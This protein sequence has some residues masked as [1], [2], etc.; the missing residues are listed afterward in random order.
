MPENN[1]ENKV[2]QQLQGFKLKPSEEVWLKVEKR[3]GEKKKRRLFFLLFLMGGLA[4]LGY[5]QR[6]NLFPKHKLSFPAGKILNTKTENNTDSTYPLPSATQSAQTTSGSSPR[7]VQEQPGITPA[8]QNSQEDPA[9]IS[10]IKNQNNTSGKRGSKTIK[11]RIRSNANPTPTTFTVRKETS[12][13][14]KPDKIDTLS[15]SISVT[16]NLFSRNAGEE[17]VPDSGGVKSDNRAEIN[18]RETDTISVDNLPSDSRLITQPQTSIF[19]KW[20]WGITVSPGIVSFHENLFSLGA[21]KSADYLS[22]GPASGGSIS[23]PAVPSKSQN[24]IAFQ[25]GLSVTQHFSKRNSVSI[26]LQ[27]GYYTEKIKVGNRRD[28][29]LQ[30]ASPLSAIY[31]A[32]FAYGTAS[33]ATNFTNRYHFIELPVAFQFRITKNKNAAHPSYARLG[34]TAG[35]LISARALAY[36]TSFGGIYYENS[37]R[38][39][40]MQFSL[41]AGLAWTYTT[42]AKWEW[43]AGPSFDIH[44]SRLTKNS[45]EREK[46]MLFIGLKTIVILPRKK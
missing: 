11:S 37:S 39:N 2:Q 26:M 18:Q 16:G 3:I 24:G 15:V 32:R 29:I 40:K 7:L 10:S 42:Q 17:K 8:K 19:K 4:L 27:Y 44:F 5:W 12:V 25:T 14:S 13:R 36:D 34:F 41:S 31:N 46:Y 9:V 23:Q 6:Y 45:M 43:N 20:Q 1:F 38:I 22:G 33:P 21:N 35:G 28:S 30:N